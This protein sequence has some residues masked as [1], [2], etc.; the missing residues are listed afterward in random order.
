[1]GVSLRIVEAMETPQER[2]KG[3]DGAVR[4]DVPDAAAGE[5]KS[6]EGAKKKDEKDSEYDAKPTQK[7]ELKN[8]WVRWGSSGTC[9]GALLITRCRGFSHIAPLSIIS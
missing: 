3:D 5:E 8:Y 6:P 1:M 4:I 7:A 9:L 2:V